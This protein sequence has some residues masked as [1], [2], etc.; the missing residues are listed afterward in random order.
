MAVLDTPQAQRANRKYFHKM[1]KIPL[2]EKEREY[3]LACRWRDQQDEQAL[4]EL[5]NAYM[6]LALS[7][8]SKYRHYGLPISD[9]VQEGMLGLLHAADRFDP[10][11]GVR[12]STYANWWVRAAVQDFVLRNW[13]I[14]RT[15]TTAAQKK[16]FFNLRRLRAQLALPPDANLSADNEFLIANRLKIAR[17]E[18]TN[19]A[20]RLSGS[21]RSLNATLSEDQNQEWQ[22]LLEDPRPGPEQNAI[23]VNCGH[24]RSRW[25]GKAL[26]ELNDREQVIIRQRRLTDQNVTLESLGN[27]LGISKE[28]VR[29][30]E[31]QALGKMREFIAQKLGDPVEAGLLG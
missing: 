17:H 12:F 4:H 11:R 30:I 3:D 28:R 22:D 2:L 13:S 6:R 10:D 9:L 15:G 29:Q 26:A 5:I 14:V 27:Q 24:S 31:A 7:A 21:D 25:L 8:A 16:L 20:F 18:V 1:M 19:M 23:E